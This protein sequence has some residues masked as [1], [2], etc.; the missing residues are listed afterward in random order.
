MNNNHLKWCPG[1]D[2]A[3]AVQ[4]ELIKEPLVVCDCGTKFCFSCGFL[5]H[6]PATCYMMKEWDGK[7]Q[8]DEANTKFLAAYTKNCPKCNF[9]I[10]KEGGCQ[11]MRCTQCSHAFCWICLGNF[12]H[13]NHGCNAYNP[14]GDPTSA[15]AQLAKYSHYLGRYEAH[16]QSSELEQKLKGMAAKTRDELQNQGYTYAEA[17]FVFESLTVLTTARNL[18]KLTYVFGF[19]M[20]EKCPRSIFEHLQGQLEESVEKLSGLLE[21]KNEKPDRT[22]ILNLAANVKVQEENLMSSLNDPTFHSA[23]KQQTEDFNKYGTVDATKYDG[24]IYTA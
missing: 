3:N 6:A 17:N 10:F 5:P 2:C 12:D 7:R 8:K 23:V 9:S 14:V 4:V 24:W 13:V 15:R 20:P 19:Y 22:K 11:Y 16:A 21:S 18:L 1:T